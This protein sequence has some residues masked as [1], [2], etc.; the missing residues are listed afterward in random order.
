MGGGGHVNMWG[1]WIISKLDS[2]HF[3]QSNST[4][5]CFMFALL[6]FLIDIIF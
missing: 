6:L 3:N 5:S 2:I 1:W 4:V